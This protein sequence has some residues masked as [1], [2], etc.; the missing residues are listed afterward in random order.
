MLN[1]G[2]PQTASTSVQNFART[3]LK[4]RGFGSSI[5]L[6]FQV[7][8]PPIQPKS[9][10]L[11][12]GSCWLLPIPCR[13]TDSLSFY[14][15]DEKLGLSFLHSFRLMPVDEQFSR[16][17]SLAAPKLHDVARTHNYF[18][19]PFPEVRIVYR[20]NVVCLQKTPQFLNL[21][22]FLISLGRVLLLLAHGRGF[23]F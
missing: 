22:P 8:R 21:V 18:S 12:P 17:S 11:C 15:A 10:V 5:P 1:F 2:G 4:K 14:V 6:G 16:A 3:T 23:H 20:G 7:Q 19:E 9:R 13:R